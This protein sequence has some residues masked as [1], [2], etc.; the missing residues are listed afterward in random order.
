VI[1]LTGNQAE[2]NIF[3]ILP[4]M[5]RFPPTE[6]GLT[7]SAL[8]SARSI[9]VLWAN[10]KWLT[11]EPLPGLSPISLLQPQP[12]QLREMATL[13]SI[14]PGEP[15]PDGFPPAVLKALRQYASANPLRAGS[16]PAHGWSHHRCL[17]FALE[18]LK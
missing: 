3:D 2:K 9:S 15:A 5:E 18:F 14:P 7:G 6:S 4:P 16:I 12:A 11:Q 17:P 13:T 8:S 1:S 10:D